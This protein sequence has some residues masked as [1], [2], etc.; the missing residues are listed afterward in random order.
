MRMVGT[1]NSAERTQWSDD[2]E[3]RSPRIFQQP[4]KMLSLYSHCI[5]Y[6]LSRMYSFN[7]YSEYVLILRICSHCTLIVLSLYSHCTLIVL[8]LHSHCT[9]IVLSLHS[10]Y[11]FGLADHP[12]DLSFRVMLPDSM[13]YCSGV[14]GVTNGRQAQQADGAWRRQISLEL[15]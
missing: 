3:T 6:A 10:H 13:N 5:E 14:A 7:M 1:A 2:H 15:S 8:S 11:I 12:G 9:L 4:Q